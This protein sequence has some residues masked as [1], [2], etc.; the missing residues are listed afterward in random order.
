MLRS[1]PV[2]FWVDFVIYWKAFLCQ[3]VQE[4]SK[5]EI[6]LFG[7]KLQISNM[8]ICQN[9]YNFMMTLITFDELFNY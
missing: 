2:M 6:I 7:K 8:Q 3:T 4:P 5:F 9:V 1:L